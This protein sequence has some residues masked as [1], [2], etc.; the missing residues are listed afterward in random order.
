MTSK[1]QEFVQ[2]RRN[3]LKT[4]AAAVWGS[5]LLSGLSPMLQAKEAPKISP[6]G[7]LPIRLMNNENPLG[8]SQNT[9]QAILDNLNNASEYLGYDKNSARTHLAENIGKNLDFKIDNVILGNGSSEVI[10]AAVYAFVNQARLAKKSVQII[11]GDPTFEYAELYGKPTGAS[12]IKVPVNSKMQLDIPAMQKKAQN[13][14]GISIVYICN[15]NNPT[16]T[17]A[18]AQQIENWVN[19]SSKDILFIFDEAYAEYAGADFKSGLK[20]IK[21]GRK[22][23]LVTRTFSKIY[24][25]AGLRIGYGIADPQ[26]IK[27]LQNFIGLDNINYLAAYAGLAALADKAFAQKSIQTNEKSKKVVYDGFKELK[28]KYIPTYANFVFYEIKGDL[29]VYIDQMKSEQILVGRPFPPLLTYNRVSLGT[30]E[31]MQTFIG[32]LKKFRSQGKI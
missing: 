29:K 27:D 14:K 15:P 3:L 6:K 26:V 32:V 19:A 22:N 5:L 31:E 16:G 9:K 18:S 28:I 1:T 4:S 25:L 17:I 11:V 20:Y 7:S 24:G 8:M 23:I 13:F 30:P 10:Q 21:E 12:I 2:S